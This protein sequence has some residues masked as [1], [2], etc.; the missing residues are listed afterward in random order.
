MSTSEKIADRRLAWLT[1]QGWEFDGALRWC[2]SPIEQL[3]TATLMAYS[4]WS[5][6]PEPYLLA[7]HGENLLADS[8]VCATH[9][10]LFKD[11]DLI[12]VQAEVRLPRTT[13]YRLDMALFAGEDKFAVEYDGHD[14]HEKTKEQARKDKARDRALTLAG[15][16][17][18]RFTGSEVFASPEG[19]VEQL[20]DAASEANARGYQ[21]WLAD[22]K[23]AG[24][25]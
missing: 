1:N 23:A 6:Y 7:S 19:V 11:S 20:H 14:F 10:R 2:E 22:R 15:W 9:K 18:L 25:E 24:T 21:R 12:I 3:V 13:R 4:G 5:Q 16:R 8:G 17:V